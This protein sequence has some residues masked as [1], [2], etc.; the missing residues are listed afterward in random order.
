MHSDSLKNI[1]A[2]L[3]RIYLIFFAFAYALRYTDMPKDFGF[4]PVD[5]SEYYASLDNANTMED[6]VTDAAD[7]GAPND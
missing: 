3:L 6:G 7:T 4:P 2:S 1:V 5:Y